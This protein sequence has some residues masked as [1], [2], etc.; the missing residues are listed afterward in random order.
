[1]SFDDPA[2]E[3]EVTITVMPNDDGW[4]DLRAPRTYYVMEGTYSVLDGHRAH[5]YMVRTLDPYTEILVE[6]SDPSYPEDPP[7]TLEILL[8]QI[9]RPSTYA[10]CARALGFE[11]W[12]ANNPGRAR[13][14][15]PE[16]PRGVTTEQR[17][18][19]RRT[20]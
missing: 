2:D 9:S 4:I 13:R 16:R 20:D 15:R 17:N 14:R 18:V 11:T 12:S 6:V 10:Y 3:D 5:R 7:F 19:R 1:M 8:C